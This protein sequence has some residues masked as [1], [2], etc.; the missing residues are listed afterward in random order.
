MQELYEE[1]N[2]IKVCACGIRSFVYSVHWK[3]KAKECVEADAS[4]KILGPLVNKLGRLL[5]FIEQV[6]KWLR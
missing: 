6:F 3:A 5:V 1:K 4:D 2:H